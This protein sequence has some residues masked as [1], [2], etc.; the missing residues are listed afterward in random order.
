MNGSSNL[1][2]KTDLKEAPPAAAQKILPFVAEL[3][4]ECRA[5]RELVLLFRRQNNKQ[6]IKTFI[7]SNYQHLHNATRRS[8]KCIYQ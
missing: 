4:G 6:Y 3:T 5:M 7:N 2:L 1:P 8:V